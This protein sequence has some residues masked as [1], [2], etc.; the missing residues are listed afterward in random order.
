MIM[1]WPILLACLELEGVLGF[2]V[3]GFREGWGLAEEERAMAVASRLVATLARQVG[4]Q[5]WSGDPVKLRGCHVLAM[6]DEM[7]Q[8]VK[9][10][11]PKV[12]FNNCCLMN[13]VAPQLSRDLLVPL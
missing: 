3:L 8:P 13:F 1:L 2:R 5:W 12:N 4:K 11:E 6:A 10:P 9:L 7:F